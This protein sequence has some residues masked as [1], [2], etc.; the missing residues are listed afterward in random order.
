VFWGAVGL[1]CVVGAGATAAAETHEEF[2]AATIAQIEE[3]SPENAPLWTD[4]LQLSDSGRHKEAMGRYHQLTRMVPD[5]DHG[6]R[7]LCT[8]R[9]AFD[10]LDGAQ[11]ACQK[12]LNIDVSAENLT[13]MAL[14][15]LRTGRPLDTRDMARSALELKPD[16]VE[17]WIMVCESSIA[18]D[19]VDLL[20]QCVSNLKRVEPESVDTWIYAAVLGAA[21]GD[22]AGALASLA[23]AEELGLPAEAASELRSHLGVGGMNWWLL[24][25]GLFVGWLATLGVLYLLG[26]WLSGKVLSAAE[27]LPSR[28]TGEAAGAS[29]SLRKLYERVLWLT[30]AYYYLSLPLL[31]ATTIGLAGALVY[32]FY[33]V[34]RFP[35]YLLFVLG[36]VVLATVVAVTKAIFIGA[37]DDDPGLRLRLGEHPKLR[38]VLLEVADKIGT[39]PVDRVYLTMGA[40]M[41]VFE[42]G[43]LRQKLAGGGE[44]CL[45]LGLAVL[46]GME[47]G[48]FKSI[49]AHEYGH[50]SNRDTAGGNFALAVRR[51]LM[52]MADH[53]AE[54]DTAEWYNPA[55]AFLNGFYRVFERVS[56]GASRLQE[57]LADRWATFAY[58]SD[59]FAQGLSHVVRRSVEWEH[60]QARSLEQVLDDPQP[61]GNLYAFVPTRPAPV[62]K[63]ERDIDEIM[64]QPESPYDSH[65]RPSRR[66]AWARALE[67]ASASET[68][69]ATELLKSVEALQLK[70]TADL[71]QRL[72]WHTGIVLPPT[73]GQS[74]APSVLDIE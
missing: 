69:P 55:W 49:L 57:V 29:A 72:A 9:L 59:S 52:V 66:I 64:N 16:H 22:D 45:V 27:E 12:A 10:D 40:E 7:R 53:L 25:F 42:R 30:C 54:A 34:G 26:N 44:R 70:L 6:H 63:V 38:A 21:E 4:A 14:V 35:V 67:V 61:L 31:L 43:G 74:D 71:R 18:L 2:R 1:C 8:A 46:E 36:G 15:R 3:L 28:Q 20:I 39:R 48:W 41:A 37:P 68:E 50:F 47:T 19:D 51:S 11:R 60:H 13:A 56:Q 33:W 73:D 65:P 32:A 24:G 62:G 17:A 58:G 23:R 5:F